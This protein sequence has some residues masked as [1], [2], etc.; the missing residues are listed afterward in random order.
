[1]KEGGSNLPNIM[2]VLLGHKNKLLRKLRDGV[3]KKK[4]H[5]HKMTKQSLTR[6]TSMAIACGKQ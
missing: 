2:I 5:L 3:Y 4:Y 1:M 6:H